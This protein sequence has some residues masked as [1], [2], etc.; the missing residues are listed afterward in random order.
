ME[1]MVD[2]VKFE[3]VICPEDQF[4]HFLESIK[5]PPI[6]LLHAFIRDA[7]MGG[8]EVIQISEEVTACVAN[9]SVGLRQ[10]LQYLI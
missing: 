9:P 2:Q 10:P 8:I 7:I 6:K 5:G 4:I 3:V 1:I